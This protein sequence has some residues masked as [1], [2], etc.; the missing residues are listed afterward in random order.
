M[1]KKILFLCII[2][3]TTL[4]LN[5]VFAQ[6]GTI[7]GKVLPE[8]SNAT[9]FVT[10]KSFFANY[11]TITISGLGTINY[12]GE[13]SISVI[14]GVYD[15]LFAAKGYINKTLFQITVNE[16]EFVEVQD[17]KLSKIGETGSI[18]G[19]INPIIPGIKVEV[20]K[21][22]GGGS[23]IT[24]DDGFYEIEFPIGDDDPEDHSQVAP[25]HENLIKLLW[26]NLK[27]IVKNASLLR[28]IVKL[29]LCLPIF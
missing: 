21:F 4:S 10:S 22:G 12:N 14:P 15:L 28:I 5:L 27:N 24:R 29:P 18:S 7:K 23:A 2:V 20:N 11:S 3:Y 9:V 25:Y 6:S 26:L 19:Y 1:N 17:V 13:Y 8:D 16:D